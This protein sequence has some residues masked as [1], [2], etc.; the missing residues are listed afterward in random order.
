MGYALVELKHLDEA[1]KRYVEKNDDD[2]NRYN[3]AN[4]SL[5]GLFA[6]SAL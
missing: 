2:K 1:E 4:S 5:L 3:P 6:V